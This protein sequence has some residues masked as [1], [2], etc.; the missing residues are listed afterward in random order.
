MRRPFLAAAAVVLAGCG[1]V[2]DPLPP[3]LNLAKPV[4]DLRVVEYGDRLLVEFTIPELTTEELPL[5]RI[6]SIDLRIGPGPNP[7]DINAWASGAKA[8]AIQPQS[9]GPAKA[10][11]DARDWVG[12]E[13]VVGVRIVNAKGRASEWSNLIPI[14]VVPPLAKPSSV[15]AEPGRDGVKV[16]WTGWSPR[17]RV[18]RKTAGAEEGPVLLGQSTAPAFVDNTAEI[19]KRYEYIVQA[20]QNSAESEVA[21]VAAITLRD[22]F[23]PGAP[24]GLNAV[25]GIGS[26]ELVWERNTEAD[27]RGYRIYRA[28]TG[29]GLERLGDI[30]DAPAFSDR[31]VEA[32]KKYR[33]AI[34]AIDQAGNESDRSATVEAVAP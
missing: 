13:V 10:A 24:V 15:K 21:D 26:I 9:P 25:P 4:K 2:G 18:F 29:G 31:Q 33:Y 5:T 23:P 17:Y 30:I 12:K 6:D 7:F 19:G 3:A 28:V 34:G 27:L 16:T 1:Y 32:G 20:F 22:V 14:G 8:I 11:V